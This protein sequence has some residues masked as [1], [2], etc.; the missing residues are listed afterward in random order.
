M[1]S[2]IGWLALC[3]LLAAP[4]LHADP[5]RTLRERYLG[6]DGLPSEAAY[7]QAQGIAPAPGSESCQWQPIFKLTYRSQDLAR[8][9]QAQ[10]VATDCWL[11]RTRRFRAPYRALP[12]WDGRVYQ[13]GGTLVVA[14]YTARC[15]QV[16]GKVTEAGLVFRPGLQA[17]QVP[18]LAHRHLRYN[19]FTGQ[20]WRRAPGG[21]VTEQQRFY[22]PWP[23]LSPAGSRLSATFQV[24]K[25]AG[26][27]YALQ[28]RLGE[29]AV[30]LATCQVASGTIISRAPG[31][32]PGLG[33][34]C[35]MA[36]GPTEV[37]Q[38]R[39]RLSDALTPQGGHLVLAGEYAPTAAPRPRVR[40]DGDF[41]DWRSLPG[42]ADPQGDIT[43]HLQ[44]SPDTDLLEF[45]VAHDGRRLYFYTR[46]AG[47]HGNTAPGDDRYYYYVYIDADRNPA[48]G[49][50]PTRDD[51][52]YYGV[53]LGD[54]CEAQ[55]EFVGGRFVKS[56]FG[57]TGAGGHRQVLSGQVQ[58]GPS[59]Y[60]RHDERGRPRT[61]Y[62]VEYVRR[63]GKLYPTEDY[64]EG[65]SQDIAIALSPDGSE[66]EMGVELTG[67]LRDRAGKLIIAPGQRIDL[68]VGVESSARVHGNTRWA[69]DSTAVIHGYYL[70][71]D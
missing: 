39:G 1:R 12:V 67:F 65:S 10:P 24:I 70:A 18:L 50:P 37:L 16:V 28:A 31:Y 26:G 8:L 63:G 36:A 35:I 4:A 48:T 38:V 55:F 58:L 42:I 19:P 7:Q 69:A 17:S 30:D 40:I 68:A 11:V 71:L 41:A 9:D 29:M 49:Y 47:R 46:V 53:D 43:G 20:L 13:Q 62:K 27:E 54:D 25:R 32:A 61:R 5:G 6:P 22:L 64:T 21:E 57:F 3:L 23:L 51:D 60:S 15:E 56:F 52:C 33:P 59:W 34:G 44:Y 66:C 45:K 14:A 2:K